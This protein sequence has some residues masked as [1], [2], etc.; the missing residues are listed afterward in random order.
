MNISTIVSNLKDLILEVRAPYDLEITGVSNHS[1]KVKKGDL[2]ICRKGEKFDS[3]EIIPEVIEK[4]AVAVVVE[5]EIDL[6]FPH[7]Q[8]F[9][10]RY[11]EAK[12]ASLFFDEP[13]KDV[14]TFGVTGTNGKTTT[15]VMIYHMLTS[16]GE[17]GSVLTTAVKRILENSY[18]DDITTPDAITILS[19]M[20]ENKEGGGKFFALE[21]SSH[22]LVQKRVEGV[23][24]DVGIFTNISRDHLDFHGTFENYLK[25]KL[26]LFD[27]LKDDGIAILNESLADTFNRKSRKITF[28]TSKNADYR[29][30][31]IEVNWEGTRFVLETPDGL[32]R[33]FTKAIGDFNAYNAA[34]AI[35][36]LH[37]LGYDP[38]DLASSLETFT[39]VE[40]RFEVVRGAKKIGLNVV[41]D[42]AH[43]PDALEKLLKNVRKISQGRVIVVFGA[44][45][46]SD[47]GKRPMMSEVASKLADVVILTTDDPRG[48]DPEQIMEDLIKGIDKRKPYLVLFDRRE[49]IETA[50]TIANRG[51]SV[52]IAGRGHE[53]Y[54][55]ID[56]EKKVPFQ[57][58][59]VVEE[60]IRD[61][62]K[63]RKYAQ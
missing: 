24:F 46:N 4:G 16:L 21:V 3:H 52:V 44:G 39:G 5:K 53:R 13:W 48:E 63:G 28:G 6:D 2:F 47:R 27:L 35:A 36:A 23:R 30:G 58:R 1:S 11:F 41:V 22:A 32:L 60:I 25:A 7:I 54:Q 40:G 9:D 17:K 51:D 31:N 34:A 8:V 10:S 59:E 49:A 43:S 50:L 37:Q 42:F 26:H 18:Y 19:A 15:T 55:I 12:V 29:L 56:E 38:K 33:V 57:D 61:K 14:L 45:G 20:K 62:L